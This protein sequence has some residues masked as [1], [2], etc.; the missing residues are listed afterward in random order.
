MV[1]PEQGPYAS[2]VKIS[3]I[4]L[5]WSLSAGRRQV[6]SGADSCGIF[7]SEAGCILALQV[8]NHS[9]FVLAKRTEDT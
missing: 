6:L 8:R 3:C 2:P 9:V 7:D 4:G 5:K 1:A